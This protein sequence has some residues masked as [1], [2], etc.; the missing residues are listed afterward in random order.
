MAKDPRS[1]GRTKHI[2]IRNYFYREKVANKTI[3][4]EYTPTDL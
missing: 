2:V 3:A 1:H 4:F